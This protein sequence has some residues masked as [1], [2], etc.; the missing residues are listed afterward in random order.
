M[1]FSTIQVVFKMV[2]IT[3]TFNAIEL[4]SVSSATLSSIIMTFWAIG[5]IITIP[6][7]NELWVR[8]I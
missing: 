4:E 8:T 7:P 2:N 6:I 3:N 1:A 5:N